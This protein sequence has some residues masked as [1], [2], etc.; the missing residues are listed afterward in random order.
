[1]A[2]YKPIPPAVVDYTVSLST[3]WT[4][5]AAPYTQDVTVTG[6]SATAKI[7]VGLAS[8]ATSAEYDAAVNAKLHCT[9]QA[10]GQ[11]TLTAFGVKP[12]ITLPIIVRAI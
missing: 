12:T 11:I 5:S 2:T 6:L 9:A 7:E 1:M 8:N 3:T 10:A 4:G